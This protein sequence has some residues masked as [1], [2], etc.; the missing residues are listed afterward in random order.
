MQLSFT[1][2]MVAISVEESDVYYRLQ[3]IIDQHFPHRVGR[4]DKVI[5]FAKEEESHQRRYFLKLVAKLYKNTHPDASSKEIDALK[6]A[7]AKTIKLSLSQK[8]Q[9]LPNLRISVMFDTPQAI[10]FDL[11]ENNRL[12]VSYLKNYF[13]DHLIQYR[14]R[15]HTLTLF[16]N[17]D[18]TCARL[19]KLM[20]ERKHMAWFISFIYDTQAYEAFR[21]NLHTRFER[22]RRFH[23]LG[24]LLEEYFAALGCTMQD[25]FSKVRQQYLTLVKLY[26]PDRH[27]NT[28]KELVLHYRE[29]F[30]KIQTAYEM[31]KNYYQD[32]EVA[33]ATA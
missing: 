27:Q 15:T 7:H 14:M 26:H 13:K 1:P 20:G 25:S 17:N 32:S 30:E 16:P 29:K 33:C 19:E 12:L 24:G 10:I 5:V 2:E 9:L 6:N 3:H 8:N 28:S 11:G 4:K 23:T 21:Q 22:K 31:V 18:T